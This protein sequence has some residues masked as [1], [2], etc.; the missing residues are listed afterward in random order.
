MN[1]SLAVVIVLLL[2]VALAP[3][4]TGALAYNLEPFNAGHNAHLRDFH[5]ARKSFGRT[6]HLNEAV[7]SASC[8]PHG[9]YHVMRYEQPCDFRARRIDPQFP[10]EFGVYNACGKKTSVPRQVIDTA[11]S[12]WELCP[13]L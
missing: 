11:H 2:L 6:A 9:I 10:F 12:D 13:R 4:F 3:Q 8:N 7:Y 5:P 1:S